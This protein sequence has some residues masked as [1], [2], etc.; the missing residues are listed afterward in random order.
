MRRLLVVGALVLPGSVG[1]AQAATITFEDQGFVPMLPF[2][3]EPRNGDLTSGGFFFDMAGPNP[4]YQI[5]NNSANINNGTTYFVTEGTPSLVTFSQ[6]GGAPFALN[7]LDYVKWQ[8]PTL[9]A[10]TI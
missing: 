5:A 9:A 7:S 3:A 1:S 10:A 6:V 4:T 8:G 2:N